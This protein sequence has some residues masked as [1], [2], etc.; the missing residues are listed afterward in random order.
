MTKQQRLKL[1]KSDLA[2]A[3]NV[4]LLMKYPHLGDATYKAELK[5]TIRQLEEP[6]LFSDSEV[7]SCL[8]K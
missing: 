4:K 1:A 8:Y 3:N 6:S 5:E 7:E 2:D